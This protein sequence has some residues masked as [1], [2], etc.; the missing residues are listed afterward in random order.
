MIT[1]IHFIS[2]QNYSS[3]VFLILGIQYTMEIYS[4]FLIYLIDLIVR[5]SFLLNQ[6]I[7]PKYPIRYHYIGDFS[8]RHMEIM[9][10]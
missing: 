8:V 6:E 3:Y 7:S 1:Y 2:H 10:K 4:Y 9:G 5:D